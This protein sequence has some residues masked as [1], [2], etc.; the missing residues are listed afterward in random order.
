MYK[1]FIGWH[2]LK[3]RLHEREDTPTFREREI[4]WT[5]IGVNIGYEQDGK[6]TAYIRPVLIMRKF[7]RQLLLG[8]PLT[9]KVKSI[10][11]YHRLRFREQEQCA[12]LMQIRAWSANRLHRRMGQL[13]E[14]EFERVREALRQMV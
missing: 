7:S 8:V 5:S 11:Y 10:P 1:D 6:H 13:A 12:I 2:P 14:P 3:R 4:W 9:T